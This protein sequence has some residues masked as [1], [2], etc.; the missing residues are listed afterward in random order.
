MK[1]SAQK[2]EKVLAVDPGRKKCGLAVVCSEDGILHRAVV[3]C[4]EFE[5][6]FRKVYEKHCPLTVLLG[7]STGSKEIAEQIESQSQI[8]ARLV[9]ERHTTE[10]AK[11]RYFEECPPRGLWKLVPV[12]L[13]TPPVC[14]DDFAA[15]V[16][17]ER[18]LKEQC[19]DK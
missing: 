10:L 19:N 9:D 12:G 6:A 4:P 8:P 7:S 14:Y 3:P 16:L 15:V 5:M 17:A 11:L 13:Q 1:K 18:Y 2:K